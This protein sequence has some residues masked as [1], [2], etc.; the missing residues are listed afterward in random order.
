MHLEGAEDLSR[1]G[2]LVA[3]SKDE[4]AGLDLF[5]REQAKSTGLPP[6]LQ[7]CGGRGGESNVG[8]SIRKRGVACLIKGGE[9]VIEKVAGGGLGDETHLV[10]EAR[11]ANQDGGVNGADVVSRAG[12]HRSVGGI[13]KDDGVNLVWIVIVVGGEMYMSGVTQGIE[14]Q[15]ERTDGD[16]D[17][18]QDGSGTEWLAASD[19]EAGSGERGALRGQGL[20]HAW[21]VLGLSRG[22]PGWWRSGGVGHTDSLDALPKDGVI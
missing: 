6:E 17:R 4:D 20:L 2:S 19:I 9:P 14:D 21:V 10:A 12:G 16:N 5:G 3:E 13:A 11:K 1:R 18:E 8:Q 15:G 7:L 22:E